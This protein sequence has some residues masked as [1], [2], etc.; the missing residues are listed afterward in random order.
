MIDL[1]VIFSFT[2]NKQYPEVA[3]QLLNIHNIKNILQFLH[4]FSV[5][6]IISETSDINKKVK[7]M[8]P[9]LHL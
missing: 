7:E 5:E 9:I 2:I 3:P 8:A 1:S 4:A 6:F